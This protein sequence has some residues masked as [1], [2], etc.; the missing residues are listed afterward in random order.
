LVILLFGPPGSGK[1]TQSPL[2][3]DWLKIPAISTGEMLRA[4]ISAGTELGL[5]TKAAI[6]AG[7]LVSDELVNEIVAS[8]ISRP[9][10]RSGFLLDGYPRT[11]EQAR[12]L[13]GLLAQHGFPRATV[14]HFEV[15]LEALIGRLLCRRQCPKC[16][17][18]YNIL[19]RRPQRPGQCDKDGT[20]LVVRDDDREE[21]IRERLDTYEEQTRPV[22]SHYYDADY[23]L[24]SGDKSPGYVFEEVTAILEERRQ[25]SPSRS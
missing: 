5:K 25:V 10:C 9:D 18:I 19:Y 3:A 16:G 20:S 22:L 23:H 15:P 21:V 17:E 24:L 4:E 7:G 2:I 1:G 13:D 8:R 11:V 14:L 12:Y 6:A